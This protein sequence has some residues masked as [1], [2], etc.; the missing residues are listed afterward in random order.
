MKGGLVSKTGD[1][2]RWML[3]GKH[4]RTKYNSNGDVHS[5]YTTPSSPWDPATQV[6][7]LREGTEVMSDPGAQHMCLL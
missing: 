3:R 6:Q 2:E 5:A 7:V 1:T 4:T